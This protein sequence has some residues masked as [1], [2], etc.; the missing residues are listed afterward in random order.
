MGAWITHFVP[1]DWQPGAKLACGGMSLHRSIA[2]SHHTSP[3]PSGCR[4]RVHRDQKC[5]TRML[6][7]FLLPSLIVALLWAMPAPCAAGLADAIAHVKPS[8]VAVGTYP[9]LHGPDQSIRGAACAHTGHYA[10]TNDTAQFDAVSC[11]GNSDSP[12]CDP[13]SGLIPVVVNSTFVKKTKRTDIAYLSGISYAIP[14][15]H[16]RTLL[17]EAGVKQ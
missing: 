2:P 5:M 3:Y 9:P 11:L 16:V 6:P 7:I 14:V 8:N 10:T 13:S 4:W 15:R 17:G 12:T 1:A